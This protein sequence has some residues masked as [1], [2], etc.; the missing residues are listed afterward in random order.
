[1]DVRVDP[2]RY[3][4]MSFTKIVEFRSGDFSIRFSPISRGE[5][6]G[7]AHRIQVFRG[8]TLIGS[9]W[10]PEEQRVTHKNAEFFYNK[11]VH[12]CYKW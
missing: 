2:A 12:H 8:E 10:L 3:E 9:D 5:L 4:Q 6:P 7:Y 1:M 11:I